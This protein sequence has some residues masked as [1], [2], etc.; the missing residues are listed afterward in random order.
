MGGVRLIR[1]KEIIAVETYLGGN[2]MKSKTLSAISGLAAMLWMA[3]C[4]DFKHEQ[5]AR[6][7]AGNN[8]KVNYVLRDGEDMMIKKVEI[9]NNNN[10][11]MQMPRSSSEGIDLKIVCDDGYII[12][13][14]Q[15]FMS[16]RIYKPTQGQ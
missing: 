15:Y 3:G 16:D 1:Q 13:T 11:F 8:V 10:L 2:K 6:T 7:A 4:G 12:E 14:S 5:F 9:S